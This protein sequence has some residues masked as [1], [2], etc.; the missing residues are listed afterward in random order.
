MR[1]LLLFLTTL[2]LVAYGSMAVLLVWA[3]LS[4]RGASRNPIPPTHFGP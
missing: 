4:G 3:I 2:L 1:D